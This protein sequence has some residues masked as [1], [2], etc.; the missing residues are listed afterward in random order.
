MDPVMYVNLWCAIGALSVAVARTAL[1]S[2]R[3]LVS[4][5]ASV[6]IITICTTAATVSRVTGIII[7]HAAPHSDFVL[8]KCTAGLIPLLAAP[9]HCARQISRCRE[10]A[11]FCF[12]R[13]GPDRDTSSPSLYRKLDRRRD[14]RVPVVHR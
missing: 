12:C 1:Y 3:V 11:A 10:I 9:P 7:R 6:A 8:T 5:S 14:T 13:R 4:A 2:Q